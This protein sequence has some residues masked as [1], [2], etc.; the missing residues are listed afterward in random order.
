MATLQDIIQRAEALKEETA[1]NSISPD[2]AGGIMY[3]TLIYINQM[4][5]Q[6]SNPL[7]I[8]K[9]YASV[10]A[11]EADS[12]PVSD[13]TG[14]ALVPGQVV[15][16]VTSDTTS[17]DYGVIYRYDGTTDG[18]SSWTAVGRIGSL[19]L[20]GCL[21]AGIATPTTD[22]GIPTKKVFYLAVGIGTYTNFGGITIYENEFAALVWDNAWEKMPFGISPS[23]TINLL[24]DNLI[25]SVGPLPVVSTHT[26]ID[27]QIKGLLQTDGTLNTGPT[28]T[29]SDFIE[30]LPETVALSWY[31]IFPHISIYDGLCLYDEN[32]D[33]VAGIA[34]SVYG[35][36]G[37]SGNVKLS[38]YPTAKYFRFCPFLPQ[39]LSKVSWVQQLSGE[40]PQYQKIDGES[41]GTFSAPTS[42]QWQYI[43]KLNNYG[44]SFIYFHSDQGQLDMGVYN[45]S[46][47][48]W[49]RPNGPWDGW[50]FVDLPND[51]STIYVYVRSNESSAISGEM[52]VLSKGGLASVIANAERELQK[53]PKVITIGTGKDYTTLRAG[54]AAARNYNGAKVVVYPGTYNLLTEWASEIAAHTG[55]VKGNLIGNGMHVVF[56]PGAYVTCNYSPTG[57]NDQDDWVRTYFNPFYTNGT[58][59]I[60]EGA[61]IECSNTRY[62]VHDELAG[63]IGSY[64]HK[65]INCNMKYNGTRDSGNYA[66]CIGG[67]LGEHGYI[68][69][70]GG[71]YISNPVAATPEGISYHNGAVATADSVIYIRDVYVGGRIRFGAHGPSTNAS[72]AYVSGCST[73][74]IENVQE[75]GGGS[76]TLFDVT[77]WNN[78][79]R[80]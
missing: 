73:T 71:K 56:L 4:Q 24:A 35:S 8:S 33:F 31:G 68:E 5:L 13:L 64:V 48:K 16:I 44:P 6:E 70:V 58:D 78:T 61:N 57:N 40:T 15:C 60:L 76:A 67:G 28:Q 20:E 51:G 45:Y 36:I 1:L 23:N 12:A 38:N 65:Y 74:A 50:E 62:C 19:Y 42:G 53:V 17:A 54:L 80:S 47:G 29:T 7:L 32:K 72:K 75:V 55:G 46:T 39:D 14:R 66:Q 59:F 9:I 77:A 41:W 52:R 49:L 26:K 10:A 18:V 25:A 22:P 27:A 79:I 37:N 3:D 34:G 2:R 11:M 43:N 30:I 63:A 21:F 69:I